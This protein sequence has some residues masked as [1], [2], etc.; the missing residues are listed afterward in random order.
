M[1]DANDAAG[2]TCAGIA[3][4]L[5]AIVVWI[6]MHDQRLADHIGGRGIAQ[7]DAGNDHVQVRNAFGIGAQ[8]VHIARVVGIATGTPVR[9]A[10]RIEMR[11]RAAG[12]GGAA[13]A[14]LMHMEAGNTARAQAT[15]GAGDADSL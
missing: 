9:C 14:A 7:G 1:G 15:D 11:T 5:A 6:G 10:G 12:I 4:K 2:Q 8:I 3:T 13:I